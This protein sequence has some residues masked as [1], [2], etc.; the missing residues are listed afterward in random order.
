MKP[1]VPEELM[2]NTNE[3]IH[4]SVRRRFWG[5]DLLHEHPYRSEALR[6]WEPRS[7]PPRWS[8]TQD[9][10]LKDIPEEEMTEYELGIYKS[11]FPG[12]RSIE[13]FD[14]QRAQQATH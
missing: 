10:D 7:D 8:S 2:V 4:S 14:L 11:W 12:F 9:I 5:K 6:A 1:K 13:D 3:T